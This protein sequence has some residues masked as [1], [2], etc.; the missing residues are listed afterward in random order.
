VQGIEIQSSLDVVEQVESFTAYSLTT[1]VNIVLPEAFI[2]IEIENLVEN[3]MI[4]GIEIDPILSP[5]PVT[6][7][8]ATAPSA[9]PTFTAI[10]INAGSDKT[11]TDP[12]TGLVWS[13]DKY[14]NGGL[15]YSDCPLNITGT[16]EDTLYCSNRV[17][18]GPP[19]SLGWYAIPVK[20][21]QYS[22][23]LMFSEIYFTALKDR[24]SKVIVQGIPLAQT[25][26]L[27][28]LV[29]AKSA[30]VVTTSVT[31]LPGK[32]NI[33]IE[34]ENVVENAMISAIEITSGITPPS[35]DTA[36]SPVSQI[37][38]L[39]ELLIDEQPPTGSPPVT[40]P[41][42]RHQRR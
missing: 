42:L 24:V 12:N 34:L 38:A 1:V 26:D 28:E 15:V 29:G 32:S 14:A 10:R 41:N 21:G 16:E 20:P 8:I 40:N 3:G 13:A 9:L 27:I 25:M 7:P 23:K 35:L 11:W 33:K 5:V 6:T 19:R 31:V 36:D 2:T 4:S 30:Y 17:F 37:S 18:I 39:V 22:V